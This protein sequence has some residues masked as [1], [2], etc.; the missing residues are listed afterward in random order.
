MA[1]RWLAE[2][3]NQI[4]GNVKWDLL[5]LAGAA[6]IPA[7]YLLFQAVRHSPSDW[8]LAV[9]LFAVSVGAFLYLGR[10]RKHIGQGTAP[11]SG[12]SQLPT[13]T[14]S[15]DAVKFFQQAYY[16][17][18]Q[19]EIEV[20][21]RAAAMANQPTDVAGFYVRLIATGLVAYMYD[22]I[23]W[24]I[25]KSQL[26]ALLE[27]NRR[28][29]ILTVAQIRAHYD[30]AAVAWPSTYADY[31]FDQWLG[32]MVSNALL[33]RH[34]SDM[35]EITIRGKDFLKYLV[36]WGRDADQRSL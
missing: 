19:P 32:F 13:T 22:A 2:Q 31:S 21:I 30:R 3:W 7:A 14:T 20:N 35:V 15:L 10:A 12:T 18:L 9:V 16:S 26:L 25:F 24:L 29:G 34:P 36:H 27:L 33:L 23:W 4:K 11:Q 8:L 6:M 17:S 5:K 1:A 28:N